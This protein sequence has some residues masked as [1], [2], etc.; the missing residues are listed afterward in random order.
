MSTNSNHSGNPGTL[1]T[2][3]RESVDGLPRSSPSQAGIAADH[4]VAFLDE[5][6]AAGLD[7]HSLMIFRHGKVAVEAWRWPYR[8]DRTRILHSVAKSFTACAVGLALE[9]R[10]FR[11]YDRVVTFFPEFLPPVVSPWLAEMTIDDLLTMRTGH[12][13]E[14]SGAEWRAINTS[15]IAEFFKIP[16]VHRPG[17]TYVYTSAASYMLSAIITKVTG[18]TLHEYLRPK[19]FEPLGI[20]GETW[21]LGPDG[22]NSGGNGLSAKTVDLL[23]I[24]ILHE[25]YG[26]W[27][28]RR[29]L[30]EAWVSSATK[31]H[32][33]PV[34]Y[35]YHWWARPD[36]IFSALG[37]FTQMSSGYRSH[38]AT[39]AV[40]CA[41]KGSVNLVPH[42]DRHFPAAFIESTLDDPLA[43]QRLAERLAQWQAQDAPASWKEPY[44]NST[45]ILT[46]SKGHSLPSVPI[47]G[48]AIKR[49]AVQPNPYGITE[50]AFSIAGGNLEFSQS[51]QRGTHRIVAGLTDW[52]ESRTNMSGSDLHHGYELN[53]SPVVARA[54]WLEP[55]TLQMTWIFAET[56]FRDT[57][58]CEFTETTVT[59][60]REVNLNGG[61]HRHED[62]I[63]VLNP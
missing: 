5:V 52:I 27:N 25:Q 38:H 7:L 39:L 10:L 43:D 26:I 45:G 21:D 8:A 57:V 28:G 14:V 36:N 48:D 59:F 58:R 12:G 42:L 44:L 60:K 40:T 11:L 46:A 2:Q 33:D 51:D 15:W 6:E 18:Q 37:R 32:G 53:N 3:A 49:F 24:G 35:G 23:K 13:A 31:P 54:C 17:S 47:M 1:H 55:G 29:L 34:K 4:V 9:D 50:L 19:I 62:L 63:G 20:E 30:D 61:P 41:I 16:I 22:I 56:A